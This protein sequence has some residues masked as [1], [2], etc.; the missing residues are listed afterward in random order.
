MYEELRTRVFLF[1]N[2]EFHLFIVDQIIIKTKL[3]YIL[4]PDFGTVRNNSDVT[5]YCH[6]FQIF[7]LLNYGFMALALIVK[8][9]LIVSFLFE[10]LFFT[11]LISRY[12]SNKFFKYI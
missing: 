2:I 9:K 8:F 1:C 12:P 10:L 5:S 7:D 11:T 6:L 4:F 3:N